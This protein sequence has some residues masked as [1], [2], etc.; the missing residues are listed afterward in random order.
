MVTGSNQLISPAARWNQ[1]LAAGEG[2]GLDG[3]RL[4]NWT[5]VAT[6]SWKFCTPQPPSSNPVASLQVITLL[7]L[8]VR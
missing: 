1:P 2:D 8:K 6:F 5:E 7:I 4:H 3:F